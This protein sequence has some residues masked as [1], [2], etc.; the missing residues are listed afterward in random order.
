MPDAVAPVVLS[1]TTFE[2]RNI[3]SISYAVGLC[4]TDFVFAGR[5]RLRVFLTVVAAVLSLPAAG[6]R[7][8]AD[9]AVVQDG[10][11]A[12]IALSVSAGNRITVGRL[13]TSHG[14][15]FAGLLFVG[16]GTGLAVGR[17]S[18]YDAAYDSEPAG[19]RRERLVMVP[20]FVELRWRFPEVG[21]V[22]LYMISRLGADFGLRRAHSIDACGSLG[23]GIGVGRIALTMA[24]DYMRRSGMFTVGIMVCF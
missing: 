2:S 12:C 1:E 20:L 23:G 17:E 9:T 10:Y 14:K 6:V 16:A 5:M 15:S 24:Y 11:A 22:D 19:Y 13:M 7:E 3:I 21:R 8:M 18:V 4:C